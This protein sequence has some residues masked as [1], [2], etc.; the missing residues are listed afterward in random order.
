MS[1]Q[2]NSDAIA[3]C[4]CLLLFVLVVGGIGLWY[5]FSTRAQVDQEAARYFDAFCKPTPENEA[6][7]GL[8]NFRL[9][10]IGKH[11]AQVSQDPGSPE[12]Y[13][14]DYSVWC[15]G[16]SAEGA[17][18]CRRRKL[19]LTVATGNAEPRARVVRH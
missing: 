2:D 4:G 15:R 3:G 10:A 7:W 1:G 14:A 17:D 19:R 6:N 8:T 18:V 9:L 11:T 13:Y 5:A 16:N 12:T